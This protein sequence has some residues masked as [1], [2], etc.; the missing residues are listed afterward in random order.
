MLGTVVSL[1][2]LAGSR[3]DHPP[4]ARFLGESLV[5]HSTE[6]LPDWA[7]AALARWIDDPRSQIRV[8]LADLDRDR[9]PEILIAPADRQADVFVARSRLRLI[10]GDGDATRL[11]RTPLSCRPP[12]LGSFRTAGWWDLPCPATR[13]V[14]RYDGL[15]YRLAADLPAAAPA[16]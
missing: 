13:Q 12:R 8:A 1:A 16:S 2:L 7:Q 4:V 14:L 11:I 5:W 3:S 6:S 9:A 10:V 15:R